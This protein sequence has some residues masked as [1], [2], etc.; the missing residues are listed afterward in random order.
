MGIGMSGMNSLEDMIEKLPSGDFI[1][2]Y[3][4]IPEQYRVFM[5]GM[6]HLL[7][8]LSVKRGGR[9][10]FSETELRGLAT[11]SRCY[12]HGYEY[13][14]IPFNDYKLID[15]ISLNFVKHKTF[16]SFNHLR[17]SDGEY[18]ENHIIRDDVYALMNGFGLWLEISQIEA[19]YWYYRNRLDHSNY[20]TLNDP[21]VVE[22]VILDEIRQPKDR[23]K[24]KMYRFWGLV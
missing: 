7:L 10:E 15:F 6:E 2:A 14:K 16:F 24:E 3:R 23:I 5:H 18:T 1:N 12:M 8:R 17:P 9:S 20:M 21:R 19:S 4:S 13:S 22:K 11:L